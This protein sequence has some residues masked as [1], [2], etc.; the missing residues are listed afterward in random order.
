VHFKASFVTDHPV[1][2]IELK[3]TRVIGLEHLDLL[4]LLGLLRLCPSKR[5]CGMPQPNLSTIKQGSMQ[6]PLG[7]IYSDCGAERGPFLDLY[8][9]G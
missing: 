2:E 5:N 7:L 9:P 3:T 1:G 8:S 6:G 4:R